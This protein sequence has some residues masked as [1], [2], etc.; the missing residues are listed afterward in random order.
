MGGS[1]RYQFTL[2][3]RPSKEACAWGIMLKHKRQ[4][5]RLGLAILLAAVACVVAPPSLSLGNGAPI[6]I[7]LSYLQ[8]VSNWG[9]AGAAGVAELV[10]KEGEVRLTATGLPSLRG[11]EYR[12][13]LV[14]TRSGESLSLA[15][16]NPTEDQV[17]RVDLVL[18]DAIPERGWDLLLVSVE[19]PDGSGSSPGTRRTIAG[20]FPVP[21]GE[22]GPAQLP[23]TGGV[24][25]TQEGTS[26]LMMGL[27]GLV[28]GCLIATA[29][30]RWPWRRIGR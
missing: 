15:G 5:V 17:A 12:A 4:V 6:S 28:A 18:A 19:T 1:F 2:A 27:L 16:F 14:N 25:T 8:G 29:L 13:W 3:S 20:R 26:L 10:F 9:P 30:W 7:V 22:R 21:G 11:E 24:E 23:R